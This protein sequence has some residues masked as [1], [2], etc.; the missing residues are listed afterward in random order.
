M[1]IQANYNVPKFLVVLRTFIVQVTG[2]RDAERLSINSHAER[3]NYKKLC[4][5]LLFLCDSLRYKKV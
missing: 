5:S 1:R 3:G 2:K 4:R